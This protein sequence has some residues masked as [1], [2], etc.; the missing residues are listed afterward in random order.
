MISRR[1]FMDFQLI[2]NRDAEEKVVV[3][4]HEETELTRVIK[5]MIEDSVLELNGYIGREVVRLNISKI[6]CILVE[7]NKVFALVGKE[8]FQLRR[9]LYQLEELLCDSFVK[10]NQSCIVNTKK[11]ER[12]D[13]TIYGALKIKLKNGYS[14]YVSRRNVKTVKERLGL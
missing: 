4:A 12:F 3:Y 10:I 11:I 8:K 9:R 6:H 5:Q 7:N 1:D 2:I 14:D 13:A